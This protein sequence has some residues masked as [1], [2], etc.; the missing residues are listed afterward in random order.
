[1]TTRIVKETATRAVALHA[2]NLPQPDPH[3]DRSYTDDVLAAHV[4]V[5]G[6]GGPA[7]HPQYTLGRNV[8]TYFPWKAVATEF[9][10]LLVEKHSFNVAGI[11]NPSP[12]TYRVEIDQ[13]TIN[14]VDIGEFLIPVVSIITPDSAGEGTFARF[15]PGAPAGFID[16]YTYTLTVSGQQLLD[17]DY[18]LGANDTLWLLAL[19]NVTDPNADPLPP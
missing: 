12:G 15:R 8:V 3:G 17:T 5:D 10:G 19:L 18:V 2:R 7:V 16:I 6:V 13:D 4:A 11:T 9:N 1:V 14:G